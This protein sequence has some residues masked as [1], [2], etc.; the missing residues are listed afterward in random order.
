MLNRKDTKS[1]NRKWSST[2]LIWFTRH[3][4]HAHKQKR[5]HFHAE[6][7]VHLRSTYSV[8][9][10]PLEILRFCSAIYRHCGLFW[11]LEY[12][13]L[14]FSFSKISSLIFFKQSY[15]IWST[16]DFGVFF[17]TNFESE[18]LQIF[19]FPSK[20]AKSGVLQILVKLKIWSTPDFHFWKVKMKIWSTPDFRTNQNLEYSR[21]LILPLK[22]QNL[23][24]V[25]LS[26]CLNFGHSRF[27]WK[28]K[29]GVLQ[30][31]IFL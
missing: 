23:V 15:K 17:F 28:L 2:F 8:G 6:T 24:W 5:R 26:V 27:W 19:I 12:S 14:L 10:I 13:R 21:S 9:H 4:P 3:C 25:K 18:V 16:Q 1:L 22:N 7:A 20:V 11:Y 31:S 29:S 30:I